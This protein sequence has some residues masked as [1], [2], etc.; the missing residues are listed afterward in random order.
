MNDNIDSELE[1]ALRGAERRLRFASEN[2]HR[3]SARVCDVG[4]SNTIPA[5]YSDEWCKRCAE[6]QGAEAALNE[7][8][9][10]IVGSR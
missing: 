10:S 9:D 2:Y 6:L 5:S 3:F 7:I 1:K 4:K 8:V